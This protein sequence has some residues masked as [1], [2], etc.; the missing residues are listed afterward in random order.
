MNYII[1]SI[2][3]LTILIGG[4]FIKNKFI[5]LRQY[6]EFSLIFKNHSIT[7][8]T[9]KFGYSYSWPTFL[10]TFVSYTDY[11]YAE[12]SKLFIAFKDKIQAFYSEDFDVNLAVSYT[13]K[14]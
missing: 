4:P 2:I 3:L 14:M 7:M 12:N 13:Y 1:L 11:E 10:V 6:R 5:Q 8:P 9:L